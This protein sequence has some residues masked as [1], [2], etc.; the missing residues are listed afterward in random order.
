MSSCKGRSGGYGHN[1]DTSK[2]VLSTCS[3]WSL[4]VAGLCGIGVLLWG[5]RISLDRLLIQIK[6]AFLFF[7]ISAVAVA[8]TLCFI[9]AFGEEDEWS[10]A[11]SGITR[12]VRLLNCEVDIPSKKF[13][14]CP[15]SLKNL[16]VYWIIGLILGTLGTLAAGIYFAI[17]VMN[18]RPWTTKATGR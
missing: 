18:W 16:N 2:K 1:E 14:G 5:I 8:I 13:G 11:G 12:M 15:S 7:Y 4:A 9:P 3:E 10:E 6:C 17:D